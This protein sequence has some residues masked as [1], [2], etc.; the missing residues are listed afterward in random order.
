MSEEGG[1]GLSVDV[2]LDNRH[3]IGECGAALGGAS[4]DDG[5]DALGPLTSA[6]TA[7]PLGD[8]PVDGRKSDRLF[9]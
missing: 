2:G 6:F 1:N 8:V 3:E 7:G 4:G 9:C 5:P